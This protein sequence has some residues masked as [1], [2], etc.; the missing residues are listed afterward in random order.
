VGA[1][2]ALIIYHLF[3]EK[4]IKNGVKITKNKN[5][6]FFLQKYLPKS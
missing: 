3:K 4:A 6:Q 5:F 2:Q 1:K